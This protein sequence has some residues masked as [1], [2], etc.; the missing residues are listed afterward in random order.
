MRVQVAQSLQNPRAV[1]AIGSEAARP[2]AA[3]INNGLECKLSTSSSKVNPLQK[4]HNK[5]RHL[6]CP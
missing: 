1:E 4:S 3:E 5:A 6:Q 2:K